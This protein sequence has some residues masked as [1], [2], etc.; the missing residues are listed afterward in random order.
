MKQTYNITLLGHSV[1]VASDAGEEHVQRVVTLVNSKALEMVSVTGGKAPEITVALLTA[2][3]IAD[4]YVSFK[5][6][7]SQSQDQIE[8]KAKQLITLIESIR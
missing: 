2:L 5:A 4:E 7:H 8:K 3:N 1:T 6:E